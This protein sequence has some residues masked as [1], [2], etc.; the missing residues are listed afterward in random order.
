MS[1]ASSKGDE[2]SIGGPR[3]RRLMALL[4]IHRST[5]VS[6]DR[7]ADAVFAGEP[8]GAASITMRYIS[9]I[10]RVSATVRVRRS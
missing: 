6:V 9:R 10:R 5:V 3:Q 4:L 1:V 7:L 2:L 8:T